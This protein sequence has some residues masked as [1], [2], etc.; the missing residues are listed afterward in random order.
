M[1]IVKNQTIKLV[2]RLAAYGAILVHLHVLFKT[3][4]G[5]VFKKFALPATRT[6]ATECGR[7]IAPG[8]ICLRHSYLL[9]KEGRKGTFIQAL[10]P[11]KY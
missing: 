4:A 5:A 1:P 11:Q 6:A 7:K 9:F 2:S 3:D 10:L 8:M